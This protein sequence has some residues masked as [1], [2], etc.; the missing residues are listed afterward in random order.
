[1]ADQTTPVVGCVLEAMREFFVDREPI[2]GR[3]E[4]PQHRG[5]MNIPLDGLAD[6]DCKGIP[7][8][9]VLRRFY[10]EDFPTET[11]QSGACR[12]CR[13]VLI[14]A[15]VSRCSTTFDAQGNPPTPEE[16]DHEALVLLDDAQRLEWVIC[17]AG[18][19]A[20]E[21]GLIDD[22]AIGAWS[23]DGP[24]GGVLTGLI[25]ASFQLTR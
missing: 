15:S 22:Y 6:A 11:E 13:A 1:M 25:T 5:G 19:I 8:V 18:A 10:S 12:K 23:P 17:R 4:A 21:R 14:Q 7:I 16:M 3:T 24:D 9:S 2:G 20:E